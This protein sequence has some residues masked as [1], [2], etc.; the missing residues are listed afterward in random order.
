MPSGKYK[1]L[2]LEQAGFSKLWESLPANDFSVN[3]LD[4]D[5]IL[6]TFKVGLNEN[7][8]P[9]DATT[10]DIAEILTH[11]DL[12]HDNQLNN[13]AMV[14]FA[15]QMPSHYSQCFIRMGRFIDNTMD[16]VIDSK[17]LRGNAFQVLQEAQDFVTKHLPISSR[18]DP[19][20]F[21]RIDEM[22]LPLLAVREAIINS[23]CHRNYSKKEG[24]ISLCIFNDYLVLHNIGHLY[25]GLTVEE[26]Y[27]NHPSRRRN[28]KIAQ[29]F[30]ARKLI[31]RFGSGTRRILRL[32]KEYNFP[33][34]KFEEYSDGFQVTFYFKEP[35]GPKKHKE[36]VETMDLSE[37]QIRVL[38]MLSQ[39]VGL[40][41][42]VISNTLNIGERT[43]RRD[44]N[45]ML[46]LG[47]VRCEGQTKNTM[48][49]KK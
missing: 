15:K 1:N 41:S 2:L 9:Q 26:L 24:D 28:E 35:I 32:C 39:S 11:F 25:G 36:A 45:Q 17:Q 49:F 3:E 37:R 4:E 48:W 6:T 46:D 12:L 31:D 29:V 19:S 21:E 30:Y 27:I 13:A 18:Y 5:E 38:D 47:I 7:R 10:S 23:I 44:L 43:L 34:P 42:S 8:I 20:Q 22:A 40:K 14:L 16:E 33:I